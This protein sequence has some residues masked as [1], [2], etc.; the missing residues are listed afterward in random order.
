MILSIEFDGGL[1]RRNRHA[2][3]EELNDT[4]G[5]YPV[6]EHREDSRPFKNTSLSPG[7]LEYRCKRGRKRSSYHIDKT[8][9]TCSSI[10]AEKLEDKSESEENFDK[11]EEIPDN[12]SSSIQ[13]TGAAG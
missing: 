10:G 3:N 9:E 13:G 11:S 6:D 7:Y 4:P 12:L 5:D 8:G 1:G 2:H